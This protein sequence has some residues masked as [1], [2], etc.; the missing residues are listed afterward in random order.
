MACLRETENKIQWAPTVVIKGMGPYIHHEISCRSKANDYS[1]RFD[2]TIGHVVH[3]CSSRGGVMRECTI[4]SVWCSCSRNPLVNPT[5]AW[6]F[7]NRVGSV[8]GSTFF[9]HKRISFVLNPLFCQSN[10]NFMDLE[11]SRNCDCITVSTCGT[12][13]SHTH[14]S[15]NIV[16]RPFIL[17]GII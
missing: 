17:C 13:P 11:M 7:G 15:S 12:F 14:K 1:G 16:L 10:F 4:E 5:V 2:M 9:P 3:T 6:L 8:L